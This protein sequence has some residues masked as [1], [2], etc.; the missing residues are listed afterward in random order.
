MASGTTTIPATTTDRNMWNIWLVLFFCSFLYHGNAFNSVSLA[1]NR[2]G[3]RANAVAWSKPFAVSRHTLY[4]S[5]TND[6]DNEEDEV[7]DETAP[8]PTTKT[9][10]S[11]VSSSIDDEVVEKND[12][13][14]DE[15]TA[16]EEPLTI[17]GSDTDDLT[18]ND[19]SSP[20]PDAEDESS[21][22]SETKNQQRRNDLKRSLLQYGASYDRGYGASPIAR[23]QVNDVI[24]ELETLS[25]VTDVSMGI[26]D[27][28]K[29]RD[30]ETG[31]EIF[32]SPL[33]GS[34]RM[35]WTTAQD[36]LVLGASPLV[37]VGAIYQVF[38]PPI[39]TNIIDFLPRPQ[40][41][42]PPS[43]TMSNLLRAKVT[44]RAS[45]RPN[46]PLRIGLDFEKVQLQP[47]ELFGQSVQDTLPPFSVNLPRLS[48]QVLS[49]VVGNKDPNNRPGYFDV[50]YL[51]DEILI[52]RQNS[53]GGL[54]VLVKTPNSDP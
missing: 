17:E 5:P 49:A 27:G 36:V 34:W 48:D 51:D 9:P 12:S 2:I 52:I 19:L 54:F 33:A 15:Q 22:N 26:D 6:K 38:T 35:I 13:D 40:A 32:V 44:T 37:T 47:V 25:Q 1:S 3:F 41:L 50:T 18:T 39:V 53:P 20:V 8:P 24:M 10:S 11:N 29:T 7:N 21:K 43:M 16:E 46:L 28:A 14:Q 30:A 45:S 23:R 42:L 31:E 4:A